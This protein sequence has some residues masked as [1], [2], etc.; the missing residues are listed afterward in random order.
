M[1]VRFLPT[2]FFIGLLF[3]VNNSF[4]QVSG[5]ADYKI[6][7]DPG[8]AQKENMGLYNYS[9][10]EKVLRVA[11]ELK[12]LF[13]SQTDIE[14]VHLSRLTD[15]DQIS[16]SER[17]DL[18]NSLGVDFYYSIHSDAGGSTANSTLTMYGGWRKNGSTVE[19]SPV[20]GKAF[21]DLLN[22]D[23]SGAMRIANRGNYA[24]RVYY[25]GE[26]YH[27][28]NQ[29]PYLHVNRTTNM[30]SLLS[31]GGFHTNPTQQ[32]RNM[33]A[34]WKK[35][36]AMSAF[37]SFLKYKGIE[38]PAIGVVT[39]IITDEDN[40]LPVNGVVVT[41]GEKHDTTD[42]YQSLFKN[43]STKDGQLRNG[44]YWIDNL[45]PGAEVEVIFSSEDYLPK[46]VSLTLATDSAGWTKDNLSFL[47]VSLTSNKPPLVE[48]VTA[49]NGLGRVIP[50]MD[51][52]SITFN[53]TMNKESVEQAISVSPEVPISF[54]W[55]DDATIMINTDSLAFNANYTF[56]IADS[57]AKNDVTGQFLDGDND[58]V[59]GG[60]YQFDI[61]TSTEDITAPQLLT[62]WPNDTTASAEI[63]PVIRMVYDEE[64]ADE[65][66]ASNI[67][68]VQRISDGRYAYG[69][70][71]HVVVNGQSVLHFFTTQ[72]LVN[73]ET[74]RVSIKAGLKDVNGN[75][76]EAFSFTFT[77][78]EEEITAKTIIDDFN[79]GVTGWWQPQASG[80]TSGIITEVTSSGA[81]TE[82]TVLSVGS[83]GS[84]KL[85]YG[86]D[87]EASG[88]YIREYLPSTA[89]QN[90]N[91][92][93]I[94]DVLQMFVMGDGSGNQF[95][96]MIKDG[97]SK[98]EASQWYTL[99]WKGWKLVSWNLSD[100]PVYAWVNGDGVLNGDNFLVDGI[101][102]R[103]ADGA[104]AQGTLWFDDLR[105]VT[106][107]AYTP[108]TDVE[109][110]ADDEMISMFP[111]PARSK[112]RI[113]TKENIRSVSFYNLSGQL[114]K[115]LQPDSREVEIKLN[116][117][118][119]GL[120]LVKIETTKGISTKK[121]NVVK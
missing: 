1:N 110:V 102:L 72:D 8:H 11:H 17:T 38:P 96:F 87:V 56:T 85:N 103:Y 78:K 20:G 73:R 55:K 15:A 42:T 80:S 119:P 29:W 23:L 24:D 39:G 114:T 117:I 62:Y 58:G 106:R 53:R 36:E 70:V 74:Y 22:V 60:A 26:I 30:A 67:V 4:A 82:E 3:F 100:D 120:Y 90:N 2:I 115:Q 46:T 63:R 13:E 25:Q 105:F 59:E 69:K 10:A 28:D 18:A 40:G 7:L 6:F 47:D 93:G 79:A 57:T 50:G 21:G 108:P 44:F 77:V 64:I 34:K 97:D 37:R 48:S 27:H 14:A 54:N 32:Q 113:E 118:E 68:S 33:N 9:E 66:V 109:L 19:K 112:V 12:D 104:V 83:T 51:P 84:M 5:L 88:Q 89:D 98:Y 94:D 116:E 43:Y 91:R 35:L 86:W 31:E 101:H 16:L 121:L 76:T 45:T 111:N 95:R 75:A 107:S 52:I 41:I 81:D 61:T 65:S 71:G 49:E 92:F 99:D